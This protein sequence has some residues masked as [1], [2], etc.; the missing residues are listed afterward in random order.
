MKEKTLFYN[1]SI[2]INNVVVLIMCPYIYFA[3]NLFSSIQIEILLL[4][5][6]LVFCETTFREKG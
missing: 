1:I 3:L 4:H 5:Q 6:R 2:N